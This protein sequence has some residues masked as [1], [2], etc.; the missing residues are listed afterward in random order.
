MARDAIDHPAALGLPQVLGGL[1]DGPTE[2][3]L[4][5]LVDLLRL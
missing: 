3:N 5:D 4:P 2:D 1:V